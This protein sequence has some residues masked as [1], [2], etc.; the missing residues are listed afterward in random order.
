MKLDD[1][2]Y[3][4]SEWLK[5]VG[6][7]S[8]VAMS[9]RARVA[10]NVAG[11]LYFSRANN[12]QREKTLQ[13]LVKAVK[14][15]KMLKNSLYMPVNDLSKLDRNF[16]VERHLMSHEH[17]VD[18]AHKGLIVEENEMISLMLNEEDHLRIQVIQ[19]GF[20]I[21]ETWR[22]LD[23]IDTELAKYVPFD[24]SDKF[25]YLTSCPTNTGTGLRASVMFHLPVLSMTGQIENVF[26]AI[27]KLGLTM[28]GFY[29]EDSEAAGDFFQISNQVALGHSEM[30]VLDNL[31]RILNK[32][33][34]REE[35]TRKELLLKKKEEISDRIFRSYG[36]L[37]SARIITSSETIKLLSSIRLG[38]DLGLIKDITVGEVN[39]VLLYM[40]PAHLQ[41]INGREISPYERDVKRADLIREKLVKK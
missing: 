35:T 40:Q 27:S 15:T 38:I 39:E 33:I 31:E 6:P 19:S 4:K 29:G 41:K 2:L 9:T 36:T 5:A 11:H 14:K 18:T 21:M 20:S 10:R 7:R 12:D 37:K 8:N 26:N 22:I 16:L 23:E 3:K 30:D 1:F 34:I 24:Y 25:G 13:L 17:M 32:I 28:R